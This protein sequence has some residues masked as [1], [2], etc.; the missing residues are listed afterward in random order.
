LDGLIV[1]NL[2]PATVE[3]VHQDT[4]AARVDTMAAGNIR[5]RHTHQIQESV[6]SARCLGHLC[7]L[8]SHGLAMAVQNSLAQAAGSDHPTCWRSLSR[9]LC[10]IRDWRQD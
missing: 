4:A 6:A 1:D 9:W 3:D 7:R 5:C 10:R 2:A 8:D